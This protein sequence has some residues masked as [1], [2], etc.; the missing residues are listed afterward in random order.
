MSQPATVTGLA[1]RELWISF[2]LLGL[3][4]LAF[5]AGASVALV[6]APVAGTLERLA[7]GLT[8]AVAAAA[9]VAAWSLAAERTTGR[10]GWLV[11]RSVSR[12]T[13]LGGWFVA[14][15]GVAVAGVAVATTLGWLTIAGF[16]SRP[17]LGGYLS[18]VASVGAWALVAVAFG[19]LL[20]VLL[21]RRIAAAAAAVVCLAVGL[22]P[23][24]APTLDPALATVV[25]GAGIGLLAGAAEAQQLI[26]PSL[27]ASGV[28]LG[29]A[30]FLLVAARM[31]FDWAEL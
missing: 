4:V 12:R 15:G 2:R 13:L 1:L 26:G 29:V 7:L 30:A 27:R 25:P 5:G 9:A 21:E 3:L 22:L 6:P 11:G 14:V 28:G 10:A 24:I 23:W 8:I 18:L 19:L 16:S 20:G 17:E 31:A